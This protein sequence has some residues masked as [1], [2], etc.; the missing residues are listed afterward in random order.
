MQ[1]KTPPSGD[2]CCEPF[3]MYLSASFSMYTFNFFFKNGNKL[4]ILTH[5]LLFVFH[6]IMNVFLSQHC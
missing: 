2:N 5:N 3:V 6:I 4:Y 1:K